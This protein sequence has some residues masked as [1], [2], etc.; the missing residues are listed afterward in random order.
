LQNHLKMN[1]PRMNP[2]INRREYH[3]ISK[4]PSD[5]STGSAFQCIA[6]VSNIIQF[7]TSFYQ[8]PI[9]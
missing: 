7:I 8:N 9:Y 1:H 6:K 3:L 2:E 4:D 5:K